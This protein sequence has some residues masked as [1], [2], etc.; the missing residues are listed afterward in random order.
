MPD[1]GHGVRG[2]GHAAEGQGEAERPVPLHRHR[3][4]HWQQQETDV[5]GVGWISPSRPYM[6]DFV[7]LGTTNNVTVQQCVNSALFKVFG[8]DLD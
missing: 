4:D 8:G 1:Q 6:I 2:Q 3:R 7:N 5:C